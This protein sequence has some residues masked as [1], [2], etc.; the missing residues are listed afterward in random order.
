[1]ADDTVTIDLATTLSWQ[2]VL[3]PSHCRS[4]M[5]PLTD[6]VAS[7]MRDTFG[8][9]TVLGVTVVHPGTDLD[10]GMIR[11]HGWFDGDT[12]TGIYWPDEMHLGLLLTASWSSDSHQVRVTSTLLPVP[13][14]LAGT[15]IEH[16]YDSATLHRYL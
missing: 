2:F 13:V 9:G 8:A 10:P 3:E 5:M 15:R 7:T 16:D 14:S 4:A 1:M 6:E 12:I 11:Q